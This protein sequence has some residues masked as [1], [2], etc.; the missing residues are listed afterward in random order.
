VTATSVQ[1][2]RKKSRLMREKSRLLWHSTS[3]LT[4]I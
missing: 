3:A 1:L 2:M 4:L